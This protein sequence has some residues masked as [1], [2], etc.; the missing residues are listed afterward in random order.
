MRP[1]CRA[2]EVRGDE[3]LRVVHQEQ[4]PLH[5][6]PPQE[7]EHQPR[8]GPLPL[9][10]P[11]EDGVEDHPLDDAAQDLALRGC[12]RE[13]E[14]DPRLP[15]PPS[16]NPRAAI[17]AHGEQRARLEDAERKLPFIWQACRTYDIS[18]LGAHDEAPWDRCRDFI[19]GW[20]LARGIPGSI[21]WRWHR[22]LFSGDVD[23]HE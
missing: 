7:D 20:H 4:A 11:L 22:A 10:R 5:V 21:L 6:L 14:G 19:S 9:P 16:P 3:H 8:Q 12:P 1:A 23:G 2:R 18:F 13:A 15:P 17:T